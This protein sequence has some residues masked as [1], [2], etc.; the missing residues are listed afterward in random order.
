[1]KVISCGTIRILGKRMNGAIR[2]IKI[3]IGIQ[4]KYY[5]VAL[6]LKILDPSLKIKNKLFI[7][8]RD[9]KNLL[10]SN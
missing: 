4:I 8:F 5:L 1:M 6:G 9:T 7:W 10:S 2:V 3:F